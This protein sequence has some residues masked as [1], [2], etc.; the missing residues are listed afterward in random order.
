MKLFWHFSYIQ[1][2][3]KYFHFELTYILMKKIFKKFAFL[4][5]FETNLLTTNSG[6]IAG[7]YLL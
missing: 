7:I 2:V 6:A 1:T 4:Q 3:A 5:K